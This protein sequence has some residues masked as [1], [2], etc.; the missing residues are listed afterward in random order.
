[1]AFICHTLQNFQV[2]GS[3]DNIEESCATFTSRALGVETPLKTTHQ[4]DNCTEGCLVMAK[5]RNSVLFFMGLYS[6]K[7]VKKL[8]LA[9]AAA[10][11]PTGII[12]HYMRPVN[13]APRLVSHDY[14]EGWHICQ[15]EVLECKEVPWPNAD[16]ERTYNIEDCGWPSKKTDYECRINLLTRKNTSGAGP[17]GV[18]RCANCEG[19]DVHA[20]RI[21]CNFQPS[22]KSVWR[23]EKEVFER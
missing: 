21:G 23:A 3:S 20:F 2:G 7:Q 18:H 19:L 10:P 1:M 13:L 22:H 6:E 11:V 12:S 4:I 14:I 8:Y 9:L 17:V 5:K 16:V 15:L